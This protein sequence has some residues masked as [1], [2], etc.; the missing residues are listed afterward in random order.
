MTGFFLKQVPFAYAPLL[1]A[2]KS[3]VGTTGRR[4]NPGE[5]APLCHRT[6]RKQAVE[7]FHAAPGMKFLL[8]RIVQLT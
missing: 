6:T 8:Q 7:I 5:H 3:R 1:N 2:A 4:L